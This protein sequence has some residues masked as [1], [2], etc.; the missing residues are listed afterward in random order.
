M[1]NE[2]TGPTLPGLEIP[3]LQAFPSGRC[4]PISYVR[5]SGDSP[6]THG[7]PNADGAMLSAL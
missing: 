6:G 2:L 1:G 3:I 7:M 5:V 4:L